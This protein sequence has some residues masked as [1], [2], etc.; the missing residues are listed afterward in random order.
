MHKE[1]QLLK[2]KNYV[3]HLFHKDG[4]GHDYY[5]MKRVA[6]MAKSI[7][8]EENGDPFICEAAGWMHDIGDKKLFSNPDEAVN[9]MT[10]FLNNIH[11]NKKEINHIKAAIKDVSFSKGNQTP[12]TLE[13]KIVQDADRL[14]A[15]GAIG[16]ARTF[17]YGGS[18]N[19]LIYHPE[20]KE[21]TSIQHFYDKLLLLKDSMNTNT[22]K[23]L[24]KKRHRFMMNF[25]DHFYTEWDQ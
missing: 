23:K 25:L 6:G 17:A 2:V 11:I 13:G 19:E 9:N 4:T 3:Y 24:A 8:L 7:S 12:D 1:Q 14:D 16:I 18:Q 10:T 15:L 22:G 21:G 5:H 20:R